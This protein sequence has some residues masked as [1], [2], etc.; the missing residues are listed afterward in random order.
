MIERYCAGHL[1]LT[2]LAPAPAVTSIVAA[3]DTQTEV[4]ARRS[5]LSKLGFKRSLGTASGH[6]RYYMPALNSEMATH[7]QTLYS[8]PE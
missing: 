7:N 8:S 5:G 4:F 2:V 1:L 6:S 3:A